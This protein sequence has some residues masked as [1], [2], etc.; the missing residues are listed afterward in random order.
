MTYRELLVFNGISMAVIFA[1]LSD[2]CHLTASFAASSLK[3]VF[4][5]DDDMLFIF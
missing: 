5:I 1:I 4:N 2:I 3:G